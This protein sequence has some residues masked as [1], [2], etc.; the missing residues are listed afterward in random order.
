MFKNL[1]FRLGLISALFTLGILISLPKIP[2]K[3][4][5]KWLKLNSSIGGYYLNIRNGK[6]ILDLRNFKKGLDLNGGIRVVMG[7]DMSKIEATQRVSALE[8]AKEI[9]SRR[10]DLLGVS[11]PH[12]STSKAGDDYRIIVEIPGLSNTEQA[13]ELIGQTAHLSFKQVK[14]DSNFD[15]TK[16]YEFFQNPNLWEETGITGSDLKGADVVF[17]QDQTN[18]QDGNSPRILLKFSDE[19]RQKFSET[20]K[21]NVGKPI[22]IFLDQSPYP[23]SMPVVSEDLAQ[24]VTS[25]PVITGSFTVESAK[26][27]SIQLRAGALPVPVKVMHQ[28]TIGATLGNESIA[29]SF[30]AALVGLTLVLLFLIFKYGKLGLLASFALCMYTALVLAIFKIIPVVLTLPG[31]AGFVLSVGM[32]TDANILIFERIKE[33]LFW[34]KPH[35][36]AIKLGFERAW[37][38]IKD[39]NMSSLI[40]SFIL[41]QFGSG[42]VRGFALTLAIGIL[43]SLFSSIFVVKTLIEVFNIGGVK[44]K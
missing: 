7:A 25:D 37:A 20:A 6:F 17:S 5:N 15:E 10:I 3:V 2:V 23:L 32:A 11:E 41:F 14:P 13:V 19:G 24:G 12:I 29:K 1:H 9:I 16:Y 43:V 31:I 8:S 42:P 4:D 36:L 44:T 30:L 38:S 28:E 21:K 40:T 34:G 22:G 35:S 26:N 18:L 39:S 27:L 33:E